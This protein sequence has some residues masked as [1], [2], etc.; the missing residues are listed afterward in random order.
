[1]GAAG[2]FFLI[3]DTDDEAIPSN[4][5]PGDGDRRGQNEQ[6][7]LQDEKGIDARIVGITRQEESGQAEQPPS[8]AAR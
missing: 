5:L 6:P 8:L 2:A 3:T 1:M 4:V 7:S